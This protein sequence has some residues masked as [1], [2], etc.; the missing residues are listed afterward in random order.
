MNVYTVK[1]PKDLDDFLKFPWKV[2]HN[3]PHWIPP[4]L[5]DVKSTLSA[6]N[7][8]F[9][10][11][12]LIL[13]LAEKGN[14]TVGRIAGIINKSHIEFHQENAGFFGYFECLPQYEI[15]EALFDAVKSWLKERDISIMRGPMS[16]STND[17]CAFLVEGFDSSPYFMMPYNPLY[18]LEFTERYGFLKARDLLAYFI[19]RIKDLSGRLKEF[20]EKIDRSNMAIRSINMNNFYSELEIVKD[21]YNSAWSKNWGFIPM[22]SEEIDYLAHRLKPL[23]VPELVLICEVNRE[24]AGFLMALP[25]YNRILKRLNGKLGLTGMLKFL[26]LKNKIDSIR[27]MTMGVKKKYRKRGLDSLLYLESFNNVIKRGVKQAELSWILE[28]N[29]LTCRAAEMMGGKLYK[30]YRIYEMPI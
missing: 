19:D 9:K 20:L 28:E 18:Y 27:L 2:Y 14:K 15:A 21:I 25:D 6:S 10:H 16:P 12:E 23:I 13:F 26:L 24:P 30:R 8:F 29:I 22:T 1:T 17:E 7:P 3:N 5:E 4:L 11:S